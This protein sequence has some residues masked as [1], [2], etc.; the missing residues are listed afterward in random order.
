[1]C[2]ELQDGFIFRNIRQQEAEQAV[3]IE[4][5]CFPPNEACTR[6]MMIER[7]AKAPE[8][9]LVAEDENTG[10]LA[11]FLSGL[12]TNDISFHDEFFFDAEL[13]NPEGSSIMIL[14]LNVLPKYRKKGLA[15]ELMR[16]YI[17]R[18]EANGRKIMLLTCLPD[19]IDMYRKMGFIDEGIADSTW[20]GEKWHE[21]KYKFNRK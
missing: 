21:M 13:Y 5:I 15:R 16:R 9:F 18:E 2:K 19:K 20:G 8:L 14:G 6:K 12:S 7:I 11:G 3:M 4:N 10:K 17:D 1:M